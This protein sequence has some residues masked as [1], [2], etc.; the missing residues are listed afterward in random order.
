MKKE[1]LFLLVNTLILLLVSGLVLL[2]YLFIIPTSKLEKSLGQKV[3]FETVEI[4]NLP[5]TINEVSKVLNGKKEIGLLYKAEK[6]NTYGNIK[7]DVVLNKEGKIIGIASNID[8]QF[9]GKNH[10]S[11][12]NNYVNALKGSE[13]KNPGNS[14]IAKPT[15]SITLGTIDELLKDVAIAGGFIEEKLSIYEELFGEDYTEEEQTKPDL[16]NI[17]G[18]KT[19]LVNGEVLAHVYHITGLGIYNEQEK[20]SIDLNI[21]LSPDYTILGAEELEYN[22]TGGGFKKKVFAYLDELADAKVKIDEVEAFKSDVTGATNSRTLVKEMLVELS[23]L[24]G[25]K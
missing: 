9:P 18:Y 24:L 1:N 3:K 10:P 6:N 19:I 21:I 13:I 14:D 20:A 23:N 2:S 12:V 22:H 17:K 8:Q 16:E 5:N 25:G 11:E 7:L 15:V 4:K